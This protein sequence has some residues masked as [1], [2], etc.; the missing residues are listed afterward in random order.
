MLILKVSSMS[1]IR[2][3][4]PRES[5]RG[6]PRYLRPGSSSGLTRK[7]HGTHKTK[8]EYLERGGFICN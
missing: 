1:P 7:C 8:L 3:M 5:H 2:S 6:M 4:W